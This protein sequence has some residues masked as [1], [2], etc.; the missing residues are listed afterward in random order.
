MTRM[1]CEGV[2]RRI[3]MERKPGWLRAVACCS[4]NKGESVSEVSD[5]APDHTRGGLVCGHSKGR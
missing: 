3:V 2:A 1:A 4:P 5:K